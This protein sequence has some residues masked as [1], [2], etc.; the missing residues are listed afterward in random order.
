[1][2]RVRVL[3]VDDSAVIRRMLTDILSA[4]P[5]I[6]VVAAVSSGEQAL[7]KLATCMPDVV[8]LDIEMPGLSGLDT[9][10]E[11]RKLA[12]RLAVIMFSSLTQRA[13]TTTLEALARGATDYVTK[14]SDTG[15]R[16]ASIEQVRSQL[17]PKI[18]GLARPAAPSITSVR[19]RQLATRHVEPQVIAI[20]ASTGG[21]NALVTLMGGLRGV[22]VPIAI[23]QHMPAVFTRILAERL[24]ATSGL[25]VREGVDEEIVQPGRV[26][27]APGDHHLTLVR[28]DGRVRVSI[29]RGPAV[30]SCRPA[31]DVLFRSVA[32][33]Y[34]GAVLGIVLTG[35]GQDGLR[36]CEAIREAGGRI[37]VQDEASSVVW[38]MPGAVAAAGLADDI[39]PITS[40]ASVVHQTF[41][42]AGKVNHG[43]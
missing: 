31:A 28:E 14:P 3:I 21:P 15:S 8:T 17:V 42:T 32:T 19:S 43:G 2:A 30:N 37:A 5:D 7:A 4:D 22:R 25:D 11:L 13:A 36:G 1:M 34:R 26:Y 27:V 20:A 41:R 39:A 35:M 33:A 16:E 29:S 38:G 12:P 24:A 10:V 40:L 23:V 18:K 9:L 6:E